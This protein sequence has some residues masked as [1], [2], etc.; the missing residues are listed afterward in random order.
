MNEL[1][2]L[3]KIQLDELIELIAPLENTPSKR[4]FVDQVIRASRSISNNFNEGFGTR[5]I[6]EK[7]KFFD[8]SKRSCREVMA[9]M[10]EKWFIKW[11]DSQRRVRLVE[12]LQMIDL[13]LYRMIQY[14]RKRR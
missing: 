10:D 7:L 5:M 4:D 9:M 8:Y 11:C 12:V 13:Q 2:Q 3:V 1:K 14:W 6:G